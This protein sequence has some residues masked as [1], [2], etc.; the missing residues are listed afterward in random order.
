MSFVLDASITLAWCFADEATKHTTALLEKLETESAFVPEL[1][2]LEVGNILIA[3]ERKKRISYAKM[4][5]FLTLI[6]NLDIQVDAET[7]A[8]AFREIISLAH[9]EHLTTYDA[10][11]LELAMRL[12]LPLATKDAAL[13]KAAKH[14]GIHVY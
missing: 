3:A 4:T 14:L 8:R 5:E 7:A 11:Y 12:G 10:A 2:S 13:Q 9:S 6:E 1:W